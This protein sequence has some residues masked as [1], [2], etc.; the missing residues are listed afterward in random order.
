MSILFAQKALI[1]KNWAALIQNFKF[2]LNI[3]SR[4]TNR[5]DLHSPAQK[6]E[7]HKLEEKNSLRFVVL[8]YR[9]GEK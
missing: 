7:I 4:A 9:K 6:S 3:I 1:L 5:L 8:L 2:M